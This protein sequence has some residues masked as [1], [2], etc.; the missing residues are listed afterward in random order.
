MIFPLGLEAMHIQDS[1]IGH[2]LGIFMT[3]AESSSATVTELE[4]FEEAGLVIFEV[5]GYAPESVLDFVRDSDHTLFARQNREFVTFYHLQTKDSVYYQEDLSLIKYYRGEL[6]DRAAAFGLF[7]YPDERVP[8][9]IQLLNLYSDRFDF[10]E[11]NPYL[12]YLSAYTDLTG[13]PASFSF[14]STRLTDPPE[15]SLPSQVVHFMPDAADVQSLSDLREI[16]EISLERSQSITLLPYSWFI[17]QAEQFDLFEQMIQSYTGSGNI[18]APL[19]RQPDE[20]PSTNWPVILLI[21]LLGSY[22]IHYRMSIYYRHSL[23]RY[24]INHNFFVASAIEYRLR[25]LAPGAVLFFQHVVICGL[26]TYLFAISVFTPLGLEAIYHSFPILNLFGNG[27]PG[28][29]FSGMAAA[30]TLQSVSVLWIQITN[31]RTRL[32]QSLTFY[33]WPLHLNFIVVLLM[34]ALHQAGSAEIWILIF[35]LLFVSILFFSF[36]IAALDIARFLTKF[37][38]LY[39][40]S[41]VG[42]HLLLIVLLITA[43][44]FYPPLSEP[45]G[46]ALSL[47]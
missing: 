46:L 17:R 44:L 2:V 10:S 45:V 28:F 8:A 18:L 7:T 29:F 27:A 9:I 32:N 42:L 31:K 41:T 15:N 26:F 14:R 43:F 30:F 33:V 21:L 16:L 47:P 24:F 38:V 1:E 12:Y 22:L 37:R 19:P 36:N 34:T 35:S 5:E 6:G 25:S 39:V 3:E 4:A 40:I 20:R 13:Y 11:D 23:L